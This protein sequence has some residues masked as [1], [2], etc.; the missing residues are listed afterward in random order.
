MIGSISKVRPCGH[1][2]YYK[3]AHATK[4]EDFQQVDANYKDDVDD[5][6]G[7]W[8]FNC[9]NWTNANRTFQLCTRIKKFNWDCTK[10]LTSGYYCFSRMVQSATPDFLPAFLS[11]PKMINSTHFFSHTAYDIGQERT[12]FDFPIATTVS[13]LTFQNYYLFSYK[14]NALKATNVSNI[15]SEIRNLIEWKNPLP[16][17][18]NG[19]NAFSGSGESYINKITENLVDF[20][21]PLYK[22][23][24]GYGMF[25]NRYNLFEMKFP[26]DE[27]RNC[28]YESKKPQLILN[29]IPQFEYLT[30]PKLSDGTSM[31][32]YCI[33]DK[34]SALSILNSLPS[35]TKGTHNFCIG[36]DTH[37]QYDPDI[38]LALKKVDIN[39]VPTC[40][41]PIDEETGEETVVTTGKGWTLTVEWNGPYNSNLEVLKQKL[42]FDEIVLPPNYTRLEYLQTR[43][44]NYIDTEYTPSNTTGL[45][46][47]AK[48][49]IY[50]GDNYYCI[51]GSGSTTASDALVSPVWTRNT[52]QVARLG[53][54]KSTYYTLSGKGDGRIY[55]GW[56]NYMNSREA[57]MTI[58]TEEYSQSDLPEIT[59]EMKN[60]ILFGIRSN[61]SIKSSPSRIYRAQITEGSEIVRDFIPCLNPQGEPC[62]YDIIQGREYKNAIPEKNEDFIYKVATN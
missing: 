24:D 9:D 25:A 57:R 34:P 47:M 54:W 11:F 43:R 53:N 10:N 36:I 31:F 6:D 8:D 15:C 58:D 32:K 2:H 42:Q 19:R 40:N 26:I 51:F 16:S 21:I 7:Y 12:V 45:Y 55:E 33:L 29:G 49:P 50:W 14:L 20:Q 48:I 23:S 30:L 13:C 18:T 46:I 41:L 4:T 22:L 3:Y 60:L 28:T 38:N 27:D 17:V 52:I 1:H 5:I 35:Y 56:M 37:L 62:M 59:A 61:D 44:F 39:Y